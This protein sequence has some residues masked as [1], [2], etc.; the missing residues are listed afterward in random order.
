[1]LDTVKRL[2]SDPDVS[3]RVNNQLKRF[4]SFKNLSN[5]EWFS[6][7]CFCLLTSN[8]KAMTA[9]KIQEALGTHG[10]MHHTTETIRETI[11]ANKHRFHN[12]KTNYIVSAREHLRIKDIL[13]PLVD[14]GGSSAAREWLVAN[15]KGFSYKE[16]SHFLRNVGFFDLAIL[17]RHILN[18]MLEHGVMDEKPA[19]LNRKR[20]LMIEETFRGLSDELGISCAE[21][22]FYM[23]YMRTGQVLK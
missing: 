15:I 12:V 11:I 6:E 7:L 5:D 8:S 13:M 18:L 4:A 2:K 1:M 23:W 9:M 10:F 22:D 3:S 21:L 14:E 19:T 17:D 16:S 20:Y